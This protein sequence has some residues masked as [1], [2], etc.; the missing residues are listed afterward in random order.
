MIRSVVLSLFLIISLSGNVAAQSETIPTELEIEIHELINDERVQN[1]LN[2][3]VLRLHSDLIDVAR[4][5][6]LDMLKNNF[7]E[8]TNLDGDTPSDRV[9]KAGISYFELRENLYTHP[10]IAE[11]NLA[12]SAVDG[13]ISS[14]GHYINMLSSTSFTG[15]GIANQGFTYYV[16]QLFLTGDESVLDDDGRIYENSELDI[17]VPE[18]K[19]FEWRT[20]YTI[21]LILILV[22]IVGRDANRRNQESFYRRRNTRSR[23]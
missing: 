6:S 10:E 2:I 11:R 15:I 3:P 19:G 21:V 1:G 14:Q 17:L 20:E 22:V 7:F 18:N 8:H 13:W 4:A 16:T 23:R 9:E 12:R 5:H